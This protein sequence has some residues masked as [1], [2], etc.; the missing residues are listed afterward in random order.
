MHKINKKNIFFLIF[1][2]LQP[3]FLS[4]FYAQTG[5]NTQTI[6]PRTLFI[7]SAQSFLG[8][9]YIRGGSTRNG[10]DCSGFI[11]RAALDGP[12]IALPRTVIALSDVSLRIADTE[13]M[14]GDLLFF[15]TTGSISHV[16][17]YLGNNEF[18]HSASEGRRTGVIISSL[19]ESYWQRAYRYAGRILDEE[20]IYIAKKGGNNEKIAVQ[21]ASAGNTGTIKAPSSTVPQTGDG[22][23]GLRLNI[24]GSVL[25][26]FMPDTNFVRGASASA[27]LS[28]V[29]GTPIYPGVEAGFY[30]DAGSESYSIP[31]TLS[32]AHSSGFRFYIGT[33]FHIK[34]A[35]YLDTSLQFPGI[36]GVS[37]NSKPV[38]VFKQQISFMQAVEY[39]WF[40]ERNDGKGLRFST[41]L[42]F[43]Y[44]I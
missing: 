38:T 9:P 31:L 18:I 26:D 6:S 8:I 15:N 3:F 12:E 35:E 19:S 11:Y 28:W 5:K 43:R 44:D 14:P 40:P 1:L 30:Y 4:S 22:K 10:F 37:W 39:S 32:I 33:Q 25:W 36:I 20:E 29:K 21:P 41:G 16:G 42:T 7:Q 27:E 24:S 17:I 23:I 2:L 34:A 13:M